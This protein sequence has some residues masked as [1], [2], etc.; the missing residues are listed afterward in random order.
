M[1]YFILGVALQI[2][3]CLPSPL[4]GGFL[5]INAAENPKNIFSRTFAPPFMQNDPLGLGIS[6]L[7]CFFAGWGFEEDGL[8]RPSWGLAMTDGSG[9]QVAVPTGNVG[10][11]DNSCNV[12]YKLDLTNCKNSDL[13][14]VEKNT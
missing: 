12:F 2:V 3:T 5:Y 11:G 14:L 10:D 9:R 6:K 4:R 1:S 7:G 8:P 13:I